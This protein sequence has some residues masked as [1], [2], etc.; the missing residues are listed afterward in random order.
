MPFW[1][2][3]VICKT[4]TVGKQDFFLLI[5]ISHALK[6]KNLIRTLVQFCL[7]PITVCPHLLGMFSTTGPG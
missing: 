1:I 4:D 7:F 2:G 3:L 6:E 5:I